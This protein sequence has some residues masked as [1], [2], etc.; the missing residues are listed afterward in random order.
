MELASEPAQPL[1]MWK[2]LEDSVRRESE[3]ISNV[4]FQNKEISALRAQ[5]EIS[6]QQSDAHLN[7]ANEYHLR[8]ED[9]EG[10]CASLVR[11]LI[12]LKI[13]SNRLHDVIL[14]TSESRTGTVGLSVENVRL[15]ETASDIHLRVARLFEGGA[16]GKCKKISLGDIV[17]AVDGISVAGMSKDEVQNMFAGP[18]GTPIM[19]KFRHSA[20]DSEYVVVLERSSLDG[21]FLP[22]EE[23]FE[24]SY[25]AVRLLRD[26]IGSHGHS[27]EARSPDASGGSDD[28]VS[29][30]VD[31]VAA[32]SSLNSELAALKSALGAAERDKATLARQLSTALEQLAATNE[33]NF[34]KTHHSESHLGSKDIR[35]MYDEPNKVQKSVNSE[36]PPDAALLARKLEC[37]ELAWFN[38]EEEL[39]RA[40]AAFELASE[41]ARTRLAEAQRRNVEHTSNRVNAHYAAKDSEYRQ[42]LDQTAQLQQELKA[43]KALIATAERDRAGLARQLSQALAK[44]ASTRITGVESSCTTKD[45]ASEYSPYGADLSMIRQVP[46]MYCM[47]KDK[48]SCFSCFCFPLLIFEIFSFIL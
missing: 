31:A 33:T 37:A 29:I 45:A 36:S 34:L 11:D 8:Y 40:R 16:A 22:S 19:F 24:K 14:Q 30:P 35:L 13:Q 25:R 44:L 4:E 47:I 38:A 9:V 15:P 7:R 43:A 6:L 20:T 39:S 10:I 32:F 27:S 28:S 41:E 18:V 48:F 3:L 42:K 26:R 17:L 2:R 23:M 12:R 5:L 46:K 21:S 1:G